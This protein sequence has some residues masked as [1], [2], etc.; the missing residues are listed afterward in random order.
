MWKKIA[1]ALGFWGLFLALFLAV[2]PLFAP[3]DNTGGA[4][5]HEVNAKGFLGEP[6]DTIDVLILGDS[7][8]Y[9]GYIPLRI[10]ENYG[11][12]S[13][14]C[15]TGDQML[16]QSY[17]YLEWVLRS[18]SPKV[19]VLETNAFYREFTAAQMLGHIAEEQFPYL[20]YHD[21]W[22]DLKLSDLQ[23]QVTYTNTQRDKGY[24]YFTKVVPADT[25]GYMAP[26]EESQPVPLLN[27]TYVEWIRDLC[28]QEGLQLILVSTPS[29]TNWSSYYHN[30]VAE[31][32]RELELDY[33]DMN[34]MQQEIPIDWSRDSYDGGDHLNYSGAC[35]VTDHMGALLWETGLFADKREDPRYE[36]W[37]QAVNRFYAEMAEKE[38]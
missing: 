11:I 26:S 12:T 20:R 34:L 22:K 28:R 7:E 1:K 31:L 25:T 33:L 24:L 37:H 9:S 38:A 27:R 21:R 17:S 32:A 35:K 36:Q 5:I 3:K 10:W 8:A 18:Q 13:Y 23:P 4:G 15:S 16:Y 2:S 6:E 30:G 14:V 19:V 29:P